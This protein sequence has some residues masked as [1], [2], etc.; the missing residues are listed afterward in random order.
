MIA[1]AHLV[2]G[3]L[4][5]TACV[6]YLRYRDGSND[7]LALPVVTNLA[8]CLSIYGPLATIYVFVLA[9]GEARA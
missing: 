4:V 3:W 6:M 1:L 9:L 7:P 2:A 8:M 5:T